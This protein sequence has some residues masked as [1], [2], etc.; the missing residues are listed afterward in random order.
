MPPSAIRTRL[1]GAQVPEGPPQV[2]QRPS[3]SG[4]IA[5]PGPYRFRAGA[6]LPSAAGHE[7]QGFLSGV[8]AQYRQRQERGY[9]PRSFPVSESCVRRAGVRGRPLVLDSLPA[10]RSGDVAEAIVVTARNLQGR[11]EAGDYSQ[12][13]FKSVAELGVFDFGHDVNLRDVVDV[14]SCRTG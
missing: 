1:P 4:R 13:I 10:L 12:K 14:T 8:R 11:I 3:P 5:R 9:V 2:G 6:P 7:A